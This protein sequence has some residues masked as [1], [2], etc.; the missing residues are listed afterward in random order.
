MQGDRVRILVEN[1]TSSVTE[2][3]HRR[4]MRIRNTVNAASNRVW[5]HSCLLEHKQEHCF[6]SRSIGFLN[7][8]R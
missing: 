1:L 5:V 4:P 2:P 7:L 6:N 3:H 8:V